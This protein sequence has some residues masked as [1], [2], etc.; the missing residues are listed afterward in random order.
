MLECIT[1]ALTA[2]KSEISF[3][4]WL[5]LSSDDGIRMWVDDELVIDNWSKG[6]TNIVTTPKNI[7]AG[8]KYKIRIE[9]WEGGWGA[10]AHF[11]WNLEKVNLQPA[12]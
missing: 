6:G 8:K 4:G 7:E 11:R 10:R 2:L 1:L 3:E 5:G 12:L 9:M